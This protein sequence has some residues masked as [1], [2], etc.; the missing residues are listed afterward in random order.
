[1]EQEAT[2]SDKALPFHHNRL[3]HEKIKGLKKNIRNKVKPKTCIKTAID[4]I[5]FFPQYHSSRQSLL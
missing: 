3:T 2:I 1:V 4:E 5:P